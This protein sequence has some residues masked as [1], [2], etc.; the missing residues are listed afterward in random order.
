MK[1]RT[2]SELVASLVDLPLPDGSCVHLDHMHDDGTAC[3]E[4][5]G[6]LA[7]LLGSVANGVQP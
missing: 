5:N 3:Y 1:L 7:D 4:V 2:D 6:P